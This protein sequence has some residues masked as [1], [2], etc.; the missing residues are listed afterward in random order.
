MKSFYTSWSEDFIKNFNFVWKFMANFE[1]TIWKLSNIDKSNLKIL[2]QIW[3]LILVH[4]SIDHKLDDS[5][6][7]LLIKFINNLFFTI[8]M[9]RATHNDEGSIK[10]IIILIGVVWVEEET[11]ASNDE[12]INALLFTVVVD[13]HV[14]KNTK[15]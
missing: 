6:F 2:S 8:K 13:A 12:V 7:I 14:S 5:W 9:D 11:R 15:G 4:K 3:I 10:C 1:E